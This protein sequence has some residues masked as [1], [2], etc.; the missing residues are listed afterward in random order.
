MK[1]FFNYLLAFAVE[2]ETEILYNCA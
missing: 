2:L 1:V